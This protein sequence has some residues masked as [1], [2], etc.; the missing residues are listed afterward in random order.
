MADEKKNRAAQKPQKA[1][2]ADKAAKTDKAGKPK[3]PNI[4]VRMGKSI[5]RFCK[6]FKAEIKKIVWPNGKTVFKSTGVVLA[7]VAVIGAG[8]WALDW[9]LGELITLIMGLA[10]GAQEALFPVLAGL[11]G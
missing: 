3:K 9:I 7:C 1:E 11:L 6:D 10:P 8:V 4:F 2:K 5:V